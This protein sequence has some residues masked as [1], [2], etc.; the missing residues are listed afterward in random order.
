MAASSE[1]L[2]VI[3]GIG[4]RTAQTIVDFFSRPRH[5]ELV[6]KLRRNGVRLENEPVTQH[7]PA[8]LAGMTFVI[9]GTLPTMSREAAAALVASQGGKVTGSVSKNTTYLLAGENPGAAK[10]GAAQKLRIP[11]LD[12]DG[13]MRLINASPKDDGSASQLSLKL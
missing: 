9:T 3:P 8:P 2:Q 13:L 1:E 4:P 12:E 10:Y 5:R 7:G 6:E 11:V